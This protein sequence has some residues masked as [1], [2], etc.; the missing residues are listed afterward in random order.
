MRGEN[1]D[2]MEVHKPRI[3]RPGESSLTASPQIPAFRPRPYWDDFRPKPN[4]L[5]RKR[6][7]P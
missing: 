1:D 2:R 6:G 3:I 4:N 7:T 5:S